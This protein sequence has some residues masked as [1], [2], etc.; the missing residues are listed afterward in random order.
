LKKISLFLFFFYLLSTFSCQ[1]LKE[2]SKGKALAVVNG[3]K[4]TEEDIKFE[5]SLVYQDSVPHQ[6]KQEYLNRWIENELLYQ[7]A[8]RR[9]L[10]DNPEVKMRSRQ[11]VKDV[12]VLSF[13]K[14]QISK[15]VGISEEEARSVYEQN[16]ELFRREQD[17][18]KASHILLSTPSQADS[19]YARIK[20]GE[21]FSFLAQV[22]S[23]DSQT[24]NRGGDLGYFSFS[25][26][27]PAI[28]KKAFNLQAGKVSTPFKTEMGY[29]ILK[30]TDKKPKGSL[31]DFAEVKDRLVNQLLAEKKREAVANLLDELKNKAKI[32]RFGWAK[33]SASIK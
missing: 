3:Q 26:M 13:L 21:D 29:H 17:E 18:V 23:L 11:A 24:R 19:V 31:R 12:V 8:K 9:G 22:L 28:A 25:N 4:L 32:E 5:L 27:H 20:R 2:E 7:E 6:A 14:E 15:Q 10:E 33:D 16:K 1:S 30:V